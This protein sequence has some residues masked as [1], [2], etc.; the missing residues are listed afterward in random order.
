M[1]RRRTAASQERMKIIT[2]LAAAKTK[3]KKEDDFGR[4]DDDWDVYNVI[5]KVRTWYIFKGSIHNL[6]TR[7]NHAT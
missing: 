7:N 6:P 4:N 5:R 3:S 1:A 2:Q